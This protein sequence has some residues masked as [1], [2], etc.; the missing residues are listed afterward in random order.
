MKDT[1]VALP[2]TLGDDLREE[3]KRSELEFWKNYI[4]SSPFLKYW[5]EE[6]INPE[7]DLEIDIFIKGVGHMLNALGRRIDVLDAGSGPGSILSHAFDQIDASLVATDPLA[8]EY[9]ELWQNEVCKKRVCRPVVCAGEDLAAKFGPRAFDVCHIRNALDHTANPI[10][11]I[12]QFI[13]VTRPKGFIVIQ[14]FENE[15]TKMNWTG[16]HQWNIHCEDN[17]MVITGKSGTQYG[18]KHQF[19]GVV[20]ILRAWSKKHNSGMPWCGAIIQVL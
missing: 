17:D 15:A 4:N 6:D 14:G 11:V 2:D 3:G 20:K 18:I 16:F 12:Q 7:L 1:V 10:I 9:D 8:D 13:H 19:R 5:C